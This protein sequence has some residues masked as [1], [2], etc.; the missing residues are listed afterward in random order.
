MQSLDKPEAAKQAP[1][2][3]GVGLLLAFLALAAL[4]VFVRQPEPPLPLPFDTLHPHT[5]Q[6]LRRLGVKPQRVT[7]GL[8]LAP[9]S[10]GIHGSDGLVNH[11]PYC[12]AFDLAVSDLSPHQTRV[13][14]HRLRGAGL[15][16]W[17]RVPGVSFPATTRMG[18]ETGPHIHGVDPFVPHKRRLAFQVRDY[19]AGNNG[20][21]V[22]PYAHRP[23]PPAACPQTAAERSLLR[24]L[25][26]RLLSFYSSL[27]LP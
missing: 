10:A 23:D 8:G 17:W 15:V 5:Q 20:I 4:V 1:R 6:T 11:R 14:L 13:L 24:R 22:G 7:Q 27:T 18:V 16:C 19:L 26:P 25:L 21:E 12:A 9:A 3:F 2:Q